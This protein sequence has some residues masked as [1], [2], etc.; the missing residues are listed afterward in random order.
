MVVEEALG[1]GLC[2]R[3]LAGQAGQA[4][5]GENESVP[6]LVGGVDDGA[7]GEQFVVREILG[8]V[9]EDRQPDALLFRGAAEIVQQL[10][11]VGF[12]DRRS[13]LTPD[14]LVARDRNRPQLT[15]LAAW[16]ELGTVPNSR[17]PQPILI[18]VIVCI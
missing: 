1:V 17:H 12:D 2:F 18:L 13:L 7:Q 9:D 14:A 10:A 8:F 15:P 6:A 11:Q 3:K 16:R 5:E 4:G